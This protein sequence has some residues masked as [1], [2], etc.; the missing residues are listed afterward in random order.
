MIFVSFV[1]RLGVF[2]SCFFA[3]S[4]IVGVVLDL[5]MNFSIPVCLLAALSM[6][7][8]LADE[9]IDDGVLTLPIRF[10]LVEDVK[11]ELKGQAMD[12]W[13]EPADIE[14]LI[15][16]ELNRIW[17]PAKIRFV[18]ES[19]AREPLLSP[20]NRDEL[21][22]LVEQSKRGDE[23]DMQSGRTASIGKLLDPA[24]R[25]PTALNV[26]LLPFI[27]ST[28][29]GYAMLG[30]R[31]TVVGVWSDKASKG[32][33]PP[34]KTLLV[35]SEPMKVGSLARTIAHELGHNLGLT[36]PPKNLSHPT[37]RLMGGRIQGYELTAKEIK[38]ARAFARKHGATRVD[39][40]RI[41]NS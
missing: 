33:K 1:A 11:M 2:S 41:E 34:V 14:N 8:T 38:K 32:K 23:E 24:K 21:I 5:L 29:Q 9:K 37:P 6:A 30:G 4:F 3:S 13:V 31:Q 39:P 28:Y 26:Y 20:P 36:H 27:G 16:P 7:T 10:H 18:I 22:R 19:C 12:M 15:M 40:K 35:E 25:H 17:K